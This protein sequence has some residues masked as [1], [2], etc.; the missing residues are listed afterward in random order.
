MVGL[1]GYY[2]INY[3]YPQ[4][5]K[6]EY[7]LISKCNIHKATQIPTVDPFIFLPSSKNTALS[8]INCHHLP[9]F[10]F[11]L[12]NNYTTL[13]LFEVS[14]NSKVAE[15]LDKFITDHSN[16]DHKGNYIDFSKFDNYKV[17]KYK[18]NLPLAIAEEYLINL[19]ELTKKPSFKYLSSLN[20][21]G[22]TL[23]WELAYT[24]IEY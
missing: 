3:K 23:D 20:Y 10:K 7:S 12:E 16:R 5:R 18:W 21:N 17:F 6:E 24:K 4:V 2:Y 15:F 19:F 14:K 9:N 8:F 22:E 11:M 1:K 13:H